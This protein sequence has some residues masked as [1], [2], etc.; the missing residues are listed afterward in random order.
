MFTTFAKVLIFANT[1]VL[2]IVDKFVSK[3]VPKYI[4]I[5]D[6]FGVECAVDNF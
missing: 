3:T 6:L 5:G 2:F 1:Y 4:L